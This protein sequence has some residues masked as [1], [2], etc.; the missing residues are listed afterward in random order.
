[1]PTTD[2]PDPAGSDHSTQAGLF[3]EFTVVQDDGQWKAT[4]ETGHEIEA[5]DL[6]A[7]AI[8]TQAYRIAS[9]LR[10]SPWL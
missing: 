9:D 8:S 10:P 4:H 2:L 7:L 5:S 1:M 6:G 3:D